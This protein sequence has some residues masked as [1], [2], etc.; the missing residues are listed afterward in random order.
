MVSLWEYLFPWVVVITSRWRVSSCQHK[1]SL[2]RLRRPD[3]RVR[4]NRTVGTTKDE[5]PVFQV[6][7]GAYVI[8]LLKN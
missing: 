6:E 2:L 4:A 7:K 5:S 8:R 3:S 1:G